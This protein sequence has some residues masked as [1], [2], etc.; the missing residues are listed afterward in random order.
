[1]AREQRITIGLNIRDTET[2]FQ[3]RSPWPNSYFVDLTTSN[4][5]GPS[6]GTIAVPA[7]GIDIDLSTFTTPGL[8]EVYNESTSGYVTIGIKDPETD[9]FYPFLEVGPLEKYVVKLSR[10]ISEEHGTGSGTGTVGG[11]TN[12][13]HAKSSTGTSYLFVGAFER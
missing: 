12:T 9:V 13:M 11:N 7:E 1:M 2:E 4:P 6:P 8:C 5:V 3:Y 10:D